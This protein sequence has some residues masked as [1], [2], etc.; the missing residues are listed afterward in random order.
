MSIDRNEA[1]AVQSVLESVLGESLSRLLPGDSY[2]HL[3]SNTETGNRVDADI[4][5]FDNSMLGVV[6]LEL[7]GSGRVP[8]LNVEVEL[9]D[10]MLTG[11]GLEK[12]DEQQIEEMVSILG[13]L[14]RQ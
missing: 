2:Y 13:S 5:Y 11:V 8:V 1:S 9:K 4:E 7:T 6:V 14:K 10:G 3:A 12:L